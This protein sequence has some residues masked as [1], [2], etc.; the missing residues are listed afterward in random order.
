MA[1]HDGRPRFVT[2]LAE[3]DTAGGWRPTKATSGCIIDVASGEAMARGFAMPHSPR[4]YN[5][6][7]WVLD[8][9][10]GCLSVVDPENGQAEPVVHLPGY[11]RG[12]S[13]HGPY[14]FVGLSR[15]R[16]TSVFGG[17]PIAAQ[18]EQLKCGVAVVDLRTGRL[19]ASFFFESGVTEIFAV[20]VLPGVRC[21][22][23]SGPAPAPEEGKRIWYAP[24]PVAD[25][26][27]PARSAERPRRR[28]RCQRSP[29]SAARRMGGGLFLLSAGPA[30]ASAH[31]RGR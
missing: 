28:V 29:A 18:R 2:V 3:S 6:H 10:H 15:I 8:S 24:G 20:E 26:A 19:L 17:I 1:L 23:T 27:E 31:A 12:L 30:T 5:G 13:F 21:P 14:A 11:T 9:G 7:L 25:R 4:V 22:A 16:E